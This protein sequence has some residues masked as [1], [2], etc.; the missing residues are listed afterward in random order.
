MVH[1][2][3]HNSGT[4]IALTRAKYHESLQGSV[5]SRSEGVQLDVEFLPHLGGMFDK[6][7]LIINQEVK[8][9][10]LVHGYLMTRLTHL[11]NNTRAI[12]SAYTMSYEVYSQ[13]Y[14]FENWAHREDKQFNRNYRTAFNSFDAFSKRRSSSVKNVS[15]S[16][17]C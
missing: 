13:G 4:H 5:H 11:P 14:S 3:L 17:A 2:F 10:Y 6:G 8:Y 9:Y 1:S 7:K 16:Q 15:A 12:S